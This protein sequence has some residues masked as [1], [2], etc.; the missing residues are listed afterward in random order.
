MRYDIR[1]D[2]CMTT[3]KPYKSYMYDR[4]ILWLLTSVG[5]DFECYFYLQWVNDICNED[6]ILE[7]IYFA[8]AKNDL[9]K[10]SNAS[11]SLL[12]F[13]SKNFGVHIFPFSII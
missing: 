13:S 2:L 11:L 5:A 12:Q 9:K 4:W 6:A 3:S 7:H 1:Y 8:N 10:L